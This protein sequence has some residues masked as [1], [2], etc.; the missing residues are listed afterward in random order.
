VAVTG[1]AVYVGG[2]QRRPRHPDHPQR[3]RP[4]LYYRWFTPESGPLGAD[5]FVARGAGDGRNWSGVNGMTMASGHL[6]YATTT[7]AL[8]T[9]DFPAGLPTGP[10]TVVSGPPPAGRSWQSRALFVLDPAD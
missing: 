2:H 10:S 4:R 6:L 8:S 7:G 1:T 5:T 9:V 3:R